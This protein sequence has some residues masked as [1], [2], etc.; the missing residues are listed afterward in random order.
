LSKYDLEALKAIDVADVIEALGGHFP[1]DTKPSAK[2]F[3][4]SCCNS[5]FHKQEDKKPSMTIWTSKNICK[6]HVCDLKGDPINVAKHMLGD[7]KSACEWLHDTFNVPYLDGDKKP[8]NSKVQFK[9]QAKKVNYWSFD[10]S[11]GFKHIE[12]KKYIAQYG[13]LE[14]KQKLKLVYTFLYRLTLTTKRDKLLSYYTSRGI[15]DNVHLNKI[16]WLSKADTVNVV[17]EL[18]KHFPEEDLVEFGIIHP[19]DH[20]FSLQWKNIINVAIVPAFD[21]NT[22]LVEGFMLRP[23]DNSNKWFKG[24]E[25]RLSVPSILRPLPFGAGYKVLSGDCDIY[26]T[27]GHIDALSLPENLCF[28]AAPGVQSF[29]KEQLGVLKGRNIKLVFDQDDAGQKAAWGYT[30]VSYQD[31]T[32]VVLNNNLDGLDGMKKFLGNQGIEVK[33]RR[34]DGFRDQLLK[35]DVASVEVVTWDKTLGKDVNELLVNNNISKVF[36]E[37]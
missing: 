15:S 4:M 31:Q 27:E 18:L 5:G 22:D 11:K 6:C 2:Q 30:E 24:K 29:E 23:V 1:K 19:K 14:K 34:V 28:I 21:V 9:P 35:A 17:R 32:L 7:F 13:K 16:G 3:N 26:I 20:K 36:K 10:K 33:T 8:S 25:S 37:D 12:L